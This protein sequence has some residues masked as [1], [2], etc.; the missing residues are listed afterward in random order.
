MRWRPVA[1]V[2]RA[3]GGMPTLRRPIR[4]LRYVNDELLR[5]GEAI[6]RSSRAP[7]PPPR[8]IEHRSGRLQTARSR[9]AATSSASSTI[10]SADPALASRTTPAMMAARPA[11]MRPARSA[12]V[13]HGPP[14]RA[15]L[16][17]GPGQDGRA[18]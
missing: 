12:G 15:A 5:A 3:A 17:R 9:P 8:H 7:Q 1:A 2:A 10:A 6:I 18:G 11:S 4:T 14:R 16:A 13:I